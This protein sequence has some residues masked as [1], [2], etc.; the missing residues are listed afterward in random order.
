MWWHALGFNYI[1]HT[2]LRNK[3]L[4]KRE[5]ERAIKEIWKD[6]LASD[7]GAGGGPSSMSDFVH[8]WLI[9][10]YGQPSI[11]NEV[12]AFLRVCMCVVLMWV[13]V[14]VYFFF[15]V[16]VNVWIFVLHRTRDY[17]P[18]FPQHHHLVT[19]HPPAPPAPQNPPLPHHIRRHT[20]CWC[21][22][23][24]TAGTLIATCGS[25]LWWVKSK[26]TSTWRDLRCRMI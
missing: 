15:C 2:Q 14:C 8:Q 6:K 10:K 19:T 5:T 21:T 13:F 22:H 24:N 3:H 26:K 11:I 4:S 23:G 25:K 7:A 16:C 9:S 1:K 17:I 18:P 12:C 20:I